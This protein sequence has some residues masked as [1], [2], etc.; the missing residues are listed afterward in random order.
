MDAVLA[1]A[2]DHSVPDR[3]GGEERDLLGGDRAHERLV[4]IRCERRAEAREPRHELSQDFV[5]TRPLV[6]RGE[7][8]VGADDRARNR[9]DLGVERLD[10]DPARRA[11]YPELASADDAV[12]AAFVPKVRE[13]GAEG[14]EALRRKLEVVRLRQRQE[15]QSAAV[16]SKKSSYGSYA[17]PC[18]SR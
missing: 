13:V 6:K 2:L 17:T 5:A 14:A 15:R 12:D 3:E 9:L 1:E 7:L 10:V 16:I 18:S 11:R 8:E 4:R